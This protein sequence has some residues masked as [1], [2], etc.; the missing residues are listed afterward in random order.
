[1]IKKIWKKN[2][3]YQSRDR[4]KITMSFVVFFVDLQLFDNH[5]II[6]K[7]ILKNKYKIIAMI[8]TKSNNYEFINFVIAR[9][10]CEILKIKFV[11]LVKYWSAKK[12]N[13]KTKLFITHVIYSKI[14]IEFYSKSLT[15]LI[16]TSLTN[17][18]VILSQFWMIKH[19]VII[20]VVVAN[21]EKKI[22]KWKKNYCIHL[23]AL[24]IFFFFLSSE[25]H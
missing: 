13:D 19:E 21:F 15:S 7:C 3:F 24:K 5:S 20:D 22:L 6:E 2:V 4:K 8:N 11:E 1:M 9:E 23:K 12:Y 18:F 16:I 10:T 25:E 14:T 17:Y